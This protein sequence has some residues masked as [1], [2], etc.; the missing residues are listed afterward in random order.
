MHSWLVVLE[1]DEALIAE[2]QIWPPRSE[3][4][5]RALAKLN[6]GPRRRD[7]L[8]PAH[9]LNEHARVVDSGEFSNPAF[10]ARYTS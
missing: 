2:Y 1:I 4:L 5:R 6:L 10:A 7:W 9:V 3:F 8:V